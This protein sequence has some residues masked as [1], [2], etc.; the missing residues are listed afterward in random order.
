ML[1]GIGAVENEQGTGNWGAGV[2][3]ERAEGDSHGGGAGQ[4]AVPVRTFPVGGGVGSHSWCRA[5]LSLM[6][7]DGTAA[8]RGTQG[9][10]AATG[11]GS[12]KAVRRWPLG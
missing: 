2:G 12:R 4:V 5:G 9:P 10:A 7:R 1:E 11:H 3:L 8:A 6:R